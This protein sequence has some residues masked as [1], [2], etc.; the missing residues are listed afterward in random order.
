MMGAT[1]PPLVRR[2]DWPERLHAAIERARDERFAWG[3]CDC[4]I[5]AASVVHEMTG[6]DFG[7]PWRGRY[8]T[9][10]EAYRLLRELGGMEAMVSARLGPPIPLSLA[11]RGDVVLTRW[12]LGPALGIVIDDRAAFKSG[13]GVIWKAVEECQIAWRVGVP[14]G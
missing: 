6:T 8:H 4:C 13:V 9:P 10:R 2:A 12:P 14:D 3:R 5:W 11:C 1:L 7:A